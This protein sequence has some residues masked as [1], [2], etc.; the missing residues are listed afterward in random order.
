MISTI[1]RAIGQSKTIKDLFNKLGGTDYAIYDRTNIIVGS[2]LIDYFVMKDGAKYNVDG[3]SNHIIEETRIEYDWSDIRPDDIILDIGANIGGFT[4][5][6]ALKAKHVY[7][8]E[9]IFF[10]ELEANVN[11]NNL[12]NVT[13]LPYAIGKGTGTI[14]LSFNKVEQKNVQTF[15]LGTLLTRIKTHYNTN[16]EL[17]FLKCDCEG[18]EWYIKPQELDTFRRI[19]MEIHP[20]MD[21]T[22]LS[23]HGLLP[24]IKQNWN[25]TF[26]GEGRESYVLHAKKKDGSYLR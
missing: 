5:G 17:T 23:N 22:E 18:G 2:K 25:T 4:I 8:V 12:T 13:I 3:Y 24:Y 14:D 16:T 15:T 9:P 6:A 11:L 7:A 20:T 19:E 26:T 10:K 1:R 21:P